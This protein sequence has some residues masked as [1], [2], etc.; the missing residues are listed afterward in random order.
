[1]RNDEAVQKGQQGLARPLLFLLLKSDSFFWGF[2]WLSATLRIGN[3]HF[4][5][6]NPPQISSHHASG[7]SLIPSR[8]NSPEGFHWICWGFLPCGLQQESQH[9]KRKQ[10]YGCSNSQRTNASWQ[11]W[12]K[13]KSPSCFGNGRRWKRGFSTGPQSTSLWGGVTKKGIKETGEASSL[14]G[15]LSAVV[16]RFLVA[17]QNSAEALLT[18]LSNDVPMEEKRGQILCKMEV[19]TR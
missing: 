9:G 19:W 13:R 4:S 18:A 1:M 17:V 11:S 14:S 10:G 8:Q 3:R 6:R 16:S 15:I 12:S 7:S 5:Y 2:I